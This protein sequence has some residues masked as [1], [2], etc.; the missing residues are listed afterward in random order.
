MT[1]KQLYQ[2]HINKLDQ[3]KFIYAIKVAYDLLS[4]KEQRIYQ[5]GFEAGF[6]E[7]EKTKNPLIEYVPPIHTKIKNNPNIFEDTCKI[8]CD[9]FKISMTEI[10]GKSRQQYI[11]IPKSIIINLM[12]ELTHNSLPTIGHKLGLD[13]TTILFHVNSKANMQGLWKQDRNFSI[14]NELKHQ[15]TDVSH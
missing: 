1:I 2:K 7:S 11:I 8:V 14:F 13:H 4:D 3:N 6:K 12:R 5:L 15:L 9:Y 10:L